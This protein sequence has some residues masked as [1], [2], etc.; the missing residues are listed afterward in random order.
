MLSV[1]SK[2][3]STRPTRIPNPT[4][5]IYARISQDRHDGQGVDRQRELCRVLAHERRWTVGEEFIDN[6]ISASRYSKRQRPRYV[7]LL[8]AIR[9]GRVTRVLCFKID[10]LYRRPRELEDLID[11]AEAG[12]VE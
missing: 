10:R 2:T 9:E 7:D 8:T 12:K 1:V 6:S 4:T 11:L 3:T 5:A